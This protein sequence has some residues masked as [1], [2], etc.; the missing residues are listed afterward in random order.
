MKRTE[1]RRGREED[2]NTRGVEGEER[3][4]G[5]EERN[6]GGGRGEQEMIR[7]RGP[8]QY[9]AGCFGSVSSTRISFRR[10]QDPRALTST[11]ICKL[12]PIIV[13]NLSKK[14][15]LI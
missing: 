1:E 11:I 13:P 6:I 8:R 7:G 15:S 3:R 10:V 9:V 5:G 4:G 12:F 14:I 2:R